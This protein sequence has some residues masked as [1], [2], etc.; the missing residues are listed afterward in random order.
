MSTK[1][2][3]L[4]ALVF[5]VS[6]VAVARASLQNDYY[7][8]I[9]YKQSTPTLTATVTT[10]PTKTPSV[11]PTKTRT[12]TPTRTQ[13]P[14]PIVWINDIQLKPEKPGEG[15][16]DEWVS[17]ENNSGKTQ[18]F[19]GW[20]LRDDGGHIYKFKDG[21]KLSDDAKVKVWSKAGTNTSS[22]LY[23]NFVPVT[24]EEKKN[25]VWNDNGDCAYLRDEDNDK[26]YGKCFNSNGTF[27][28]PPDW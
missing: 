21:F 23:W 26:V 1:I 12:P 24:D 17:I 8:P 15:V 14:K 2:K 27:F 20:T 10:T 16:L 11:S 28:I 4:L 19:T 13:T 9:V 3:W 5:A 22:S 25:G 18:D 7:L 6:V